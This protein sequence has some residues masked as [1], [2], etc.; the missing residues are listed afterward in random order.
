[1]RET[2]LPTHTTPPP[3]ADQ[4]AEPA[5][6]ASRFDERGIALQTV[7]IMVV[8]L[9]IAGT[10]AA[11]LFNR[12]SD[13]T[14]ELESQDVTATRIDSPSECSR[15]RMGTVTG[16]WSPS[17]RKCTWTEGSNTATDITDGRCLLVGGT[18]SGGPDGTAA[19][20]CTLTL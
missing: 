7:I 12:A 19:H 5:R 18:L 6:Q 4:T 15:H 9:A 1:M 11:V 20:V 14:G 10:V 13:V 2:Q 3:H 16:K 17:P 8:L